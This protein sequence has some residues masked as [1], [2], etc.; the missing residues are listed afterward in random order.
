[1][2]AQSGCQLV[3]MWVEPPKK[4]KRTKEEDEVIYVKGI[5]YVALEKKEIK[6]IIIGRTNK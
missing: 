2:E 6:I 4:K 5:V 3:V 1:M